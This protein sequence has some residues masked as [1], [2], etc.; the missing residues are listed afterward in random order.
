MNI[1]K[2]VKKSLNIFAFLIIFTLILQSCSAKSELQQKFESDSDYFIALRL[3]TEGKEKEARQKFSNATKKGS[4]FAAE[5]S[6]EQLCYLGNL[7]ERTASAKK[8]L[9]SYKDNDDFKSDVLYIALNQFYNAKEYSLVLENSDKLDLQNDDNKII[10]IRMQTLSERN[11]DSLEKEVF[12]WFTS[13][14]LSTEHYQFYRDSYNHPD[15]NSIEEI[16]YTPV[17]FVLNYRIELYKRNYTYTASKAAELFEYIENNELPLLPQFISD[18]GKSFLYGSVDYISNAISFTELATQYAGTESEYYLW[19]YAGRL[20]C[21]N[22]L[23]YNQAKICFEKA[24]E[25]TDDT[26]KKDNAIWYLISESLN[27][28]VDQ[29]IEIISKYSELWT[30]AS[31]FDDFFE[32]LVSQLLTAGR[33]NDFYNIY[34]AIDGKATDESVSEYAYIYARLLDQG[35]AKAP[36]GFTKKEAFNQAMNRALNSGSSWYYKT[37]AAYNLNLQNDDLANALLKSYCKAPKINQNPE[38]RNSAK[39]L[40]EGYAAFGLP[41]MI[42]PEFQRLTGGS[43]SLLDSETLFYLSD[44]L[45]KCAVSDESYYQKSLRIA[46]KAANLKTE[47]FTKEELKLVYPQDFYDDIEKNSELYELNSSIMY[48][49]TRS[50]SFFDPEVKSSAGAVGLCQ[51]MEF[52]AS[53]IAV[54][55]KVS[56]YS[57]T[58]ASTNIKFGTYYLSSLIRRCDNSILQ[59]FFSYNAGISRVRKWLQ[60]STQEFGRKSNMPQDLFLETLPYTETRE[61][62]RKLVSASA[63]YEWLYKETESDNTAEIANSEEKSAFAQMIENLI[64]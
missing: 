22:P 61:Y 46:S 6:A 35:L 5:R 9:A 64:Y 10:K 63:M 36:E 54:S 52:T 12:E 43:N 1:V 15:F 38:L 24:I 34:T 14:A 48:A 57:L 31:Y 26:F 13:R 28:S 51:L 59:G 41:E 11:I 3:V 53:D 8:L 55:L 25:S 29:I 44:F 2:I 40:M 42:Y 49:L 30:D 4:V 16:T 17:D 19:F 27:N 32:S 37:L 60:T 18:V 21:T 56:D 23:Y 20:F 45:K 7:Q 58:D 62:G 39:L 47:N 33:W 50:E